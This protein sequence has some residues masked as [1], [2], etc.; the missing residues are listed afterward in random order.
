MLQGLTIVCSKLGADGKPCGAT[1]VVTRATYEY[2][3]VDFTRPGHCP[4]LVEAK[5]EIQCPKCG[6]RVQFERC[7]PN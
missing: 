3:N 4:D 6:P 1:A 2:A 7:Q 5:Y